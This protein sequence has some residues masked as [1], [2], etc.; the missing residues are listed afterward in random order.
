MNNKQLVIT[1]SEEAT[2]KYLQLCQASAEAHFNADVEPEL[3][4]LRI[5]LGMIESIGYF[6]AS[7]E[8]ELG[9][10]IA[11]IATNNT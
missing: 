3:P 8:I 9:N 2:E 10:V 6:I 5:E 7:E 1:F 11:E 4:S